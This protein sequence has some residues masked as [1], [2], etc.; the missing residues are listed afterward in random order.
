[1]PGLTEQ[2]GGTVERAQQAWQESMLRQ[3]DELPRHGADL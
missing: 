3:M 1:M 2:A